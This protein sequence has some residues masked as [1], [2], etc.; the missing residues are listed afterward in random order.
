MFSHFRQ[1]ITEQSAF[2]AIA[3]ALNIISLTFLPRPPPSRI[4]CCW[5]RSYRPATNPTLVWYFSLRTFATTPPTPSPLPQ[6]PK[7]FPATNSLPVCSALTVRFP[8]PVTAHVRGPSNRSARLEDLL[9]VLTADHLRL[10]RGNANP[11][12][13]Q[14]PAS[15][16]SLFHRFVFSLLPIPLRLSLRHPFIL[17]PYEKKGR[18][19]SWR[20]KKR[21]KGMKK[22]MKKRKMIK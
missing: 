11:L 12:L 2:H 21:K 7:P 5:R 6:P 20:R 9:L 17:L 10:R 19:K 1:T 4:R 14:G 18:K 13:K 16:S 3:S 15:H 22:K 8:R